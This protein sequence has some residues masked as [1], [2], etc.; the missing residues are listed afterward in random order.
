MTEKHTCGRCGSE[1]IHKRVV[2]DQIMWRCQCGHYWKVH[3]EEYDLPPKF[4]K[5]KPVYKRR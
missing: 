2:Q 3:T 5:G 1:N 4:V